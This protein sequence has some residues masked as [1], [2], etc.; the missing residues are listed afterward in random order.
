ML[1]IRCPYCEA[2]RPELEFT[3]AGEAHI[4]RP[5]DPSKLNDDEWKTHLFIR[6]NPR[7]THFER[8]RHQHGCGR[9]FNAVRDTVSDKFA[10]TYKA[11]LPRPTETELEKARS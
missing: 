3:Y 6:S 7:G 5:A 2:E 1:L 4:A 11:G 9:F 8:W 10:M